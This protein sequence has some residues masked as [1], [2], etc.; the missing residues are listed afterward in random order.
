MRKK[1]QWK[2][3]A[4]AGL[5]IAAHISAGFLDLSQ[6][7]NVISF[8]NTNIINSDIE[9]KVAVGGD[10]NVIKSYS[11]GLKADQNTPYSVVSK[12]NLS[13]INGSVLNGGIYAGGTLSV[14]N[15]NINGSVVDNGNNISSIFDFD[16]MKSQFT[17]FSSQ[18]NSTVSNGT[19][20]VNNGTINLIGTSD[21]NF[22]SLDANYLKSDWANSLSFQLSNQNSISIVNVSGFIGVDQ[23]NL[24]LYGNNSSKT[25]L[26]F[27]QSNDSFTILGS[28]NASVLAP[29]LDLSFKYGNV[30]GQ[31][32]ANS[33]SGSSQFNNF[34]FD[35]PPSP[36]PE[37]SIMFMVIMGTLGLLVIASRKKFSAVKK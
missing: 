1:I 33:V 12:G 18:L 34:L 6:G 37:N 16:A 7:Y 29:N 24:N 5:A 13:L 2:V 32:I 30:N 35:Y 9:G 11:I 4:L 21:I 17:D 8:D 22:F 26:N 36:V 3:T 20:T 31:V 23:F 14:Q 19:V 15:A 28:L 25:L 10:N 27:T